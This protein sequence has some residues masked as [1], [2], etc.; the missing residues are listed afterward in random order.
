[1]EINIS[2]L[3]IIILIMNS[4]NPVMEIYLFIFS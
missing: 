2:I 1:M 4:H 3:N